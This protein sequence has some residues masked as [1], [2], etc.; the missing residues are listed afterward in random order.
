M[1]KREQARAIIDT[2]DSI[3]TEANSYEY[4]LPKYSEE[5]DVMINAVLDI[6]DPRPGD[7]D[8]LEDTLIAELEAKV[9][10]FAKARDT[11]I[12]E[13]VRMQIEN[14]RLHELVASKSDPC[15]Y[16]GERV[17]ELEDTP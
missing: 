12:G 11:A 5:M 8:P 9:R 3:A 15:P 16:C 6:I 17:N 14:Q 10:A 7:S 13:A 4:G 1:T 2:L